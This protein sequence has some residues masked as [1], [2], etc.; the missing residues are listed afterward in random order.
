[1]NSPQVNLRV[2]KQAY[3][4]LKKY[5]IQLAPLA[6]SVLEETARQIERSNERREKE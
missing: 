2:S 3:Q 5:D 1:M 6:R 4:T